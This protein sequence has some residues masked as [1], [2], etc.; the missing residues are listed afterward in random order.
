METVIN[1]DLTPGN[2]PKFYRA[3]SGLR[4]PLRVADVLDLRAML[5]ESI[6]KFKRPEDSPSYREFVDALDSAI[7]SFGIENRRHADRLVMLL[8]KLR[9]LHYHHS[10]ASRDEEVELRGKL[11]DVQL[12]RQHSTRYGLASILT[13]IGLVIAWIA[14]PQPGWWIKLAT[15]GAA[16]VAYDFFHSLPTLEREYK[17]LN[18]EVNDL[19]RERVSNVDWKMLIHKLSLLMGYKKVSGVE[20]FSMEDD[21]DH[22][23]T[24]T[25][26]R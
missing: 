19:L 3:L 9:D 23:D 15:L 13:T 10:I 26:L 16:Y 2:F 14:I 8:T 6:D 11:D 5:N 18:T 17:T 4:F 25:I 24:L 1:K 21:L 20:V 22:S 7:H 12:A